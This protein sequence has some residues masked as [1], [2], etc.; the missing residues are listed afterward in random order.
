M[1]NLNTEQIKLKLNKIIFTQENLINSISI[2][3]S[4]NIITVSKDKSIRIYE[5]N[6]NIIQIIHNAHSNHITYVDIK[7]EDNFVTCS[8]DNSIKTWI[9]KSEL[10]ENKYIENH[11]IK[12]AHKNLIYNVIYEQN[13]KII[14]CGGDRRVIIWEKNN[15]NNKYQSITSLTHSK[16]V[17]SILLLENKNIIISSGDDGTIFWNFQNCIL[18]IHFNNAVCSHWNSLKK[19]DDKNII[20][21]GYDGFLKIISINEKQIIKNI[22]NKFMCWGICVIE[23]KGLFITGGYCKDIKIYKNDNYECIQIIKDVDDRMIFGFVRLKN[24]L[25]ASYGSNK[26]LILWSL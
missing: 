25:I 16:R 24:G 18:I 12:N 13:E 1:S 21:G 3:P 15:K 6:F 23:N 20:V 11:Y 22:E 10:N 9:K 2:F 7:N 5:M 19:L 17:L 26:K 14:S 8:F 4:G